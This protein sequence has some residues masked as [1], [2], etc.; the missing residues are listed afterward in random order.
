MGA[1]N[2]AESKVSFQGVRAVW[3][4]L[5]ISAYRAR[6]RLAAT[7]APGFSPACAALKDGATLSAY[8]LDTTLATK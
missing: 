3:V 4:G 7:V 5:G 1:G 2:A 8:L 6:Q